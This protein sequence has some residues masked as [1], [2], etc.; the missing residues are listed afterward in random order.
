[1]KRIM[2][3][4]MEKDSERN[5]SRRNAGGST[6]TSSVDAKPKGSDNNRKEIESERVKNKERDIRDFFHGGNL[7]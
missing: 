2:E 5:E 1:M 7:R 3:G 4:R 6:T